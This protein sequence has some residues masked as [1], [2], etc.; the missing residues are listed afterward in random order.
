MSYESVLSRY[1]PNPLPLTTVTVA[2]SGADYTSIKAALAGISPTVASPYKIYVRNGSYEE[3]Q[4][5]G[6]AY[7]TIEGESRTGVVINSD[8][9]RTDVD[10]VS[11]SRY[12]DMDINTK[13]GIKPMQN[14]FRLKNL[15]WS[16]NDVKYNVHSDQSGDCYMYFENC[17]FKFSN[18]YYSFG[19]GLRD[20]QYLYFSDCTFEKTGANVANSALVGS[21]GVY[22][23]N[24]N[25]QTGTG[26]SAGCRISFGRCTAINCGLVKLDELG[27]E[28]V[29]LLT[30]DTCTPDAEDGRGIYC[31][32][33]DFYWNGGGQG[34]LNVPYCWNILTIDGTLA[35]EA[36]ADKRP[37]AE[38]YVVQL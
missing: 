24:W 38:N 12:V 17:H 15:T 26:L 21:H 11:G 14:L 35:I 13:H 8:G 28:Q 16:A 9:L 22:C 3:I 2:A 7:V 6:K 31:T 29:D 37:N 4:I 18:P 33:T 34:V 19:I 23:H 36:P 1:C 32:A 10:P 30:A 20:K 5:D 27:S 25:D